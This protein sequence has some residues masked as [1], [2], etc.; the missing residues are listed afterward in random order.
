MI[1]KKLLNISIS[2]MLLAVGLILPIFTGQI[3][4]I[5]N[6]LLPMHIPVMLCGLLCG[7]Q[8][9]LG[10]GFIM[11]LMRSVIFGMPVMLPSA[12]AMSAELAAY[13]FLVGLIFSRFRNQNI[14]SVY[15]SMICAMLGG[16]IVWGIAMTIIMSA[17]G[18]GSFTFEMFTAGAF[19]N[20][21]PGIIL[22]L[23][24][25][26]A[27][28]AGLNKANLVQFKKITTTGVK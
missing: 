23:V 10:I 22:Q 25:V 21:L 4:Q 12:A 14:S 3:R 8:Y 13:G 6:M 2:A 27:I 20:A 18:N 15:I 17:S 24:L 11:P 26:P 19:L 16:R 9:G 5:G 7:W 28:I 1:N